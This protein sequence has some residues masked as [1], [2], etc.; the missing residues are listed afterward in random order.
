MEIGILFQLSYRDSSPT[1]SA[2]HSVVFTMY[3]NGNNERCIFSR[4][5]H[6]SSKSGEPVPVQDNN[7]KSKNLHESSK[8]P[9][10]ETH[11]QLKWSGHN[12]IQYSFLD[13]SLFGSTKVN[14]I[15]N[16]F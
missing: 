3:G 2:V 6:L 1:D 12:Y 5:I 14:H 8:F 13:S 16:Q 15:L 4:L 9:T 10:P 11:P 7:L